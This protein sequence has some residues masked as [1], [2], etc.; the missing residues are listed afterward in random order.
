MG[1]SWMDTGRNFL[2]KSIWPLGG[3]I[4]PCRS[5]LALFQDLLSTGPASPYYSPSKRAPISTASP[6]TPQ[7]A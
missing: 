4:W 5:P 1:V 6:V 3:H 2:T 7:A